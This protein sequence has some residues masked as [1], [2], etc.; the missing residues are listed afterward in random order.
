M[1]FCLL[2]ISVTCPVCQLNVKSVSMNR[3]LDY[4]LERDERK[5]TLRP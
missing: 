4:C 5:I 2:A 1:L 3:H